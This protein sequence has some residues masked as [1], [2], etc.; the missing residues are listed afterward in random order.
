MSGLCLNGGGKVRW[1]PVWEANKNVKHVTTVNSIS[2]LISSV[3]VNTKYGVL[4]GMR[5]LSGVSSTEILNGFD[6]TL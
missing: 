6:W 3:D 4:K 1:V 5:L 2:D